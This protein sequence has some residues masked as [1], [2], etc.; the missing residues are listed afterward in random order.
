MIFLRILLKF[1]ASISVPERS[2]NLAARPGQLFFARNI[3]D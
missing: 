1:S 3:F 2:D